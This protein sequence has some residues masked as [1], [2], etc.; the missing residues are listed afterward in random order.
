MNAGV[1]IHSTR[2]ACTG[3]P[4][5]PSLYHLLEV[6]GKEKAMQRIEQALVQN[7]FATK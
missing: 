3:N 7:G 1:F 5:G 2:L 4:H 6:L